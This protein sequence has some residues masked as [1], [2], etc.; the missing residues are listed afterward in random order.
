VLFNLTGSSGNI[1]QASRGNVLYGT[2]LAT[3]GGQFNLSQLNLAGALIN[4]GGNVQFVGDAQIKASA[5]FMPF[6]LPGIVSV[7]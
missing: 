3:N 4:V 5:P 1:L 2:Y 7:F 6:Q